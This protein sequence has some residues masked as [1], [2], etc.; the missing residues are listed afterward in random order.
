[1]KS[2]I[3]AFS[4]SRYFDCNITLDISHSITISISSSLKSLFTYDERLASLKFCLKFLETSRHSKA[5]MIVVDF[6]EDDDSNF[7]Y[8]QCF[9][10]SWLLYNEYFT[11]ESLEKHLQKTSHCLLVLQLQQ[12][13]E[14]KMIEK[15][16]IESS[17][18]SLVKF[19]DTYEKRLAILANWFW[20]ASLS[21]EIVTIAEFKNID[22]EY[23]TRCMHCS[24]TVVENRNFES[25][26]KHL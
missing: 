24:L 8:M 26:K 23:R 18:A 3:F 1:M 16:K 2:S 10:C 14:S 13:V 20:F 7:N 6:F 22:D 21:K 12:E 9:I 5:I 17:S 11:F 25:L 19:L 4:S 15:S